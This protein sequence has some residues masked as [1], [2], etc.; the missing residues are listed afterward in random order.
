MPKKKPESVTITITNKG[1]IKKQLLPIWPDA[2]RAL[3]FRSR[4]AA[5]AAVRKGRVRIVRIGN[6]QRVPL[7]WIKRKIAGEEEAL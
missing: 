7:W 1:E 2:G 6:L 3:G 4:A 5:Y